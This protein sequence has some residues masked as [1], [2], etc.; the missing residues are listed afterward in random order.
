MAHETGYMAMN[1]YDQQSNRPMHLGGYSAKL[2]EYSAVEVDPSPIQ[3]VHDR[4]ILFDPTYD[5]ESAFLSLGEQYLHNDFS[6]PDSFSPTPMSPTV[7]S[8]TGT[9]HWTPELGAQ[10]CSPDEVDVKVRKERRRAQNRMAQRGE[11][12]PV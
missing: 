2:A 4:R 8:S 1:T 10:P 3:D 6:T 5:T 11:A 12:T 7:R 9:I